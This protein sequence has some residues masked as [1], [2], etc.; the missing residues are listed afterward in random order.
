MG[1]AYFLISEACLLL[2]QILGINYFSETKKFIGRPKTTFFT[3]ICLPFFE[4]NCCQQTVDR[5]GEFSRAFV[6]SDNDNDD[7]L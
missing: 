7:H 3:H 4:R 1:K 6:A 5:A 2:K